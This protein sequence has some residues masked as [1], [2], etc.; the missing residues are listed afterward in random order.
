MKITIKFEVRITGEEWAAGADKVLRDQPYE[1]TR[2]LA[3][4]P[5]D[6]T[7]FC[8]TLNT[9][10]REQ[11]AMTPNEPTPAAPDWET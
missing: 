10:M 1:W 7:A 8:I 2:D 4:N 3:A 9:A 5:D 11:L 6:L